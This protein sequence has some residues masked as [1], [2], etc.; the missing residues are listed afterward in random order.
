M[1]ALLITIAIVSLLVLS[2]TSGVDS[3]GDERGFFGSPRS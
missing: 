1:A 2:V 3:R